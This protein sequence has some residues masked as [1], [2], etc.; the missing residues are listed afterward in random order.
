MAYPNDAFVGETL[1]WRLATWPGTSQEMGDEAR[2]A[3]WLA[4][5]KAIGDTFTTA[6]LRTALGSRL[7][8]SGRNDNE[9]FQRRIR[10]LRRPSDGWVIPSRKHI[11]T[12]GPSEYRL[13]KVGWH[14]S[15]GPRPTSKSAASAKT[16]RAVLRRDGSRCALCGIG[17]NEPY[18]G[19]PDS[20]AIM[21]VGHVRPGILDGAGEIENLR[22]ECSECNEGS[23]SDTGTPESLEALL[24]TIAN[25]KTSEVQRIHSW[26]DLG[27]RSRDRV[28][29]AFDAF[30]ALS[31]SQ[32]LVARSEISRM[33]GR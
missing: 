1:W 27:H 29:T 25:F 7:S 22:A 30:R 20:H 3:S 2:I 26:M 19:R 33:L 11:R 15:L 13:D 28:D 12:L 14:P 8:P 5:N 24:T 32:Q 31:P 4:Y 16:K 10:E 21:T 23:R 9:H 17:T 6:E 18:P